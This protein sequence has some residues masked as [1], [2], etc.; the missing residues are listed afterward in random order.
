MRTLKFFIPYRVAAKQSFRA[1]KAFTKGGGRRFGGY[2][3]PKV[4][5]NEKALAALCCP[6]RPREPLQGTLRQRLVFQYAWRKR[7]HKR[8]L[9]YGSRP[10]NTK[11][12]YEQLC[13]QINDAM[14]AMGFFT[15]DAIIAEAHVWKLWCC[16]PGV[17]VYLEELGD[18]THVGPQPATR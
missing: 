8:W 6:H 14:E 7:E 2:K 12:D 1:G 18:E 10:K 13:K 15:D 3:D 9:D 4:E 5:V 11:P 16:V 17:Q